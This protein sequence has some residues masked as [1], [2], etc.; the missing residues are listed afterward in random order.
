MMKRLVAGPVRRA[1]TL[2]ASFSGAAPKSGEWIQKEL[3]FS[4]EAVH[5]GCVP[6]EKTGA[7][8]TPIFQSTTFVQE[9]V[10]KYLDKGYSYSRTNNPTV[11]AFE[12]R[13]A[14]MENGFGAT[15]SS[16]GMAA[17]TILIASTMKAGDHCVIT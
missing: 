3:G 11:K 10:E 4:T 16:T 8:L 17:T 15:V 13:V 2:R 12:E 1:S 14:A 5:A 7:I 9:S 6:D